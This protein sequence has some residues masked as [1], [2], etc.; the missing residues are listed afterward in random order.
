MLTITTGKCNSDSILKN[1]GHNL[2]LQKENL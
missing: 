1:T 2:D